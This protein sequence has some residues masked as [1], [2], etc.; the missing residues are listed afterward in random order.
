MTVIPLFFHKFN[1]VHSL[2]KLIISCTLIIDEHNEKFD[3]AFN[4]ICITCFSTNFS[5]IFLN[6][7]LLSLQKK[8]NGIAYILW[9]QIHNLD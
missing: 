5:L 6:G 1:F 7:N 8:S 9:I 3:N 2:S 4:I